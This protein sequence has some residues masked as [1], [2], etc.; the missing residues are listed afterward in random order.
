MQGAAI[1]QNPSVHCATSFKG[2]LLFLLSAFSLLILPVTLL[3]VLFVEVGAYL[4]GVLRCRRL[5]FEKSI[6][7]RHKGIVITFQFDEPLL[8][9]AP[10]GCFAVNIIRLYMLLDILVSLLIDVNSGSVFSF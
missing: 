8:Q 4:S 6:M 7:F 2:I 9:I 10:L 3:L 5:P 1:S